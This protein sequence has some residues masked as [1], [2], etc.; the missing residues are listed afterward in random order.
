M[1]RRLLLSAALALSTLLAAATL[2]PDEG[3]WL[4]T[5]IGKLP[6]DEMRK[7]GLELT[8]EQIYSPTSPS[9]KDAVV[10]LGGG[11]ASFVSAEG[12]MITN[13]HVAFSAIQSVSSVKED[14]LKDGFWAKSRDEEISIPTYSARIVA[15]I[16]DVTSEL[17]AALSDTMSP[18]TRSKAVQAVTA[19][20][21]YSAKGSSDLEYSA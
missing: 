13:H 16:R 5:Q 8:P 18:D 15:S 7:H 14:Y 1:K 12:L 11:T 20:I 4:M 10:L 3:M 21:Q 6:I 2:F 9:L 19:K 17:L